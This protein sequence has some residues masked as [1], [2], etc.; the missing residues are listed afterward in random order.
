MYYI[1]HTMYYIQCTTYNIQCTTYNVQCTTYN[2][3]CTTYNVQCTIYNVQCT[4]GNG[5]PRYIHIYIHTPSI[6]YKLFIQ[7][8]LILK[9]ANTF[10]ISGL[11]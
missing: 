10:I 8:Q 2:I 9:A 4:K 6:N 3:Q 1:Q 11:F 7:K 5:H